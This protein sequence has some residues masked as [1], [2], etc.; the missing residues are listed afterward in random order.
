MAR[1]LAREEG[2]FAGGSSGAAVHVAVQLAHELGKGKVIVVVL[3]DTR[4]PLHQ[5]VLFGRV[6]EGQR[7]PRWT[8]KSPGTVRDLI[9]S[10]KQHVLSAEKGERIDAVVE[11][12]RK[13]G[14]SQMPVCDDD[15]AAAVGMID[16]VDLLNAPGLDGRGQVRRT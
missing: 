4:Q 6:D 15:Q 5:Q 16:E 13:H 9:G 14:I 3:P 8:T 2:L 11:Q 12:M 10:R 7:L 1:R